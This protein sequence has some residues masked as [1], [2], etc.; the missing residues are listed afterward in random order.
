MSNVVFFETDKSATE[1][2]EAIKYLGVYNVRI[3]THVLTF[4]QLS[5]E[6]ET[7]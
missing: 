1:V 6:Q 5:I 3:T 2:M 7:K 4:E